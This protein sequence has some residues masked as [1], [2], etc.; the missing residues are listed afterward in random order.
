MAAY[1]NEPVSESNDADFLAETA[2]LS[3]VP[4]DLAINNLPVHPSAE[5]EG[6]QN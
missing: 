1:S 2:D 3:R 5:R 6:D 4:N